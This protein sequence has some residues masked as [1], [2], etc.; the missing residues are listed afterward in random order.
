MSCLPLPALF[1][2]EFKKYIIITEMSCIQRGSAEKPIFL[3]V[4][5]RPVNAFSPGFLF[6]AGDSYIK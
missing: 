2:R 3:E 6:E 1:L 4:L 5:Q